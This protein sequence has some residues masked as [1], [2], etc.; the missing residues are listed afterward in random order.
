MPATDSDD[1]LLAHHPVM[2]K[3]LIDIGIGF[4]VVVLVVIIW[5]VTPDSMLARIGGI[6]GP[7]YRLN[8]AQMT[9]AINLEFLYGAILALVIT[10]VFALA[11]GVR[12]R[13]EGVRRGIVWA[14]VAA[15]C[16]LIMGI[17]GGTLGQIFGSLGVYALVAATALGPIVVGSI[18]RPA[19]AVPAED[20][21]DDEVQPGMRASTSVLRGGG[22]TPHRRRIPP[23]TLSSRPTSMP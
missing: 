15:V 6:P 5:A 11:A 20:A 7:Y 18:R 12:G 1:V 19:V 22:R 2:K 13:R 10:V 4:S 23:T 16:Y 8:E 3:L 17:G 9:Q 14:S 21:A